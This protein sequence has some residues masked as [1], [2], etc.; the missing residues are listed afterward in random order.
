MKKL[1]TGFG[2]S[3]RRACTVV[4]QHRSTQ[5]RRAK[6][7]NDEPRLVS[8]MQAAAKRHPRYGYRRVASI[9][10]RQGW[11]VN[12]KRIHRLWR[13]EGLQVPQKARK[14]R[15]LGNSD[16]G[17]QRHRAEFRDHVWSY[18]FVFDRTQDGKPIKILAVVDEFTREC[19][20]L[21]ADRGITGENI[22]DQLM[23]LMAE[24]GA[25]RHIRSDNGPEFISHAVRAW[26]KD[27]QVDTLF[28]EPGAPWQ[29]AY[30]ESF[31]GR[32][33]DE[34]L[35]CEIFSSLAE[36]WVLIRDWQ[37]EYN[38]DRP[39]R[40]LGGLTPDEFSRIERRRAADAAQHLTH[41][42]QGAC[43]LP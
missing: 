43:C 1:Q 16:Q 5:R 25:P 33:R 3:E 42:G 23:T 8:A 34:L 37:R 2:V 10:R 29:N 28:I 35:N 9:L 40:S 39:H 11:K 17:A 19:L 24:R 38:E 12:L 18:D 41:A 30:V 15:R 36:A 14:R 32:L 7:A 6:V 20:L 21:H 4:G 13:A 26:L 27:L 31:N 22:I